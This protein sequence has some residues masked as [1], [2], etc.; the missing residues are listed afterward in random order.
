MSEQMSAKELAQK[1]YHIIDAAY[2]IG[3]PMR[4]AEAEA[5]I[6]ADRKATVERCKKGLRK[7]RASLNESAIWVISE[8][9]AHKALDAV[10]E[11][12]K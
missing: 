10:M 11:S 9:E 5:L 4:Y 7:L 8:A 1:C 3:S 12:G 6:L 2:H